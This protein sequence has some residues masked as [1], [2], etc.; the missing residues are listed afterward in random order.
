MAEQAYPGYLYHAFACDRNRMAEGMKSQQ[1]GKWGFY[2][3]CANFWA[4]GVCQKRENKLRREMGLKPLPNPCGGCIGQSFLPLS[5]EKLKRHLYTNDDLYLGVYPACPDGTVQLLT[6]QFEGQKLEELHLQRA[7]D[8][9][10]IVETLGFEYL[11]EVNHVLSSARIFLF[12]EEPVTMQAAREFGMRILARGSEFISQPDF[13]SYDVMIPSRDSYQPD[14]FQDV[15]PLPLEGKSSQAGQ[16]YLADRHGQPLEAPWQKI[17]S[18][19]RISPQ[20]MAGFMLDSAHALDFLSPDWPAS[21]LKKKKPAPVQNQNLFDLLDQA[22]QEE[23]EAEESQPASGAATG[24]AN[25][26]DEERKAAERKAA[27]RNAEPDRLFDPED[28]C[29]PLVLTRSSRISVPKEK[30]SPRMQ[31]RLRQMAAYA[32][33]E[34]K[35][36]ER[37]NYSN[38]QTRR[39]ISQS[40]ETEE[41]ILLPFGLEEQLRAHLQ[42]AGIPYEIIDETQHGAPLQLS[43][44]GELRPQQQKALADLE[45]YDTGIVESATGSG[46]TVMGAALIAQKQCSALVVV[47]SREILSGWLRDMKTFLDFS[48]DKIKGPGVLG[49]GR[50]TLNGRVDLAMVQSLQKRPDLEEILSAYG[51]II[52]DECHHSFAKTYQPLFAQSRARLRYGFSATPKRTDQQEPVIYM[53]LGPVRTRFTAKDQAASQNFGRLF[54]QVMTDAVLPLQARPPL[55]EAYQLLV[56]NEERNALIQRQAR[57]CLDAGRSV[58][59]LTKHREHA[60]ILYE[61]MKN[62]A[63]QTVL[64]VGGLPAREKK[65]MKEKLEHQDPDKSFLMIGTGAYIGEGFNLPRLDTLLLAAPVSA[66][67]LISQ[68]SGRLHREYP[69]KK[70]VM[71]YDFVDMNLPVFVRMAQKREAAYIKN[72]YRAF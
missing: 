25:G 59:V 23:K 18:L 15:V 9:A 61:R 1:T 47:P 8:L 22:A 16:A 5:P 64:L 37:L 19:K 27:Q 21:L 69:G 40:S 24:P 52:V 72:G 51:M 17:R 38:Y 31:N 29:G 71:I 55:A 41:A 54:H 26:A 3:S 30:L 32:N 53:E 35:E 67:M 57:E 2:I 65:E 63:Q 28:V 60:R 10:F 62:D 13:I 39:I 42:A 56:E 33:P 49:G 44:S 12:F 34:Y 46:K 50:N 43:F 58:L 36:N 6:W 14:A 11:F 48:Q 4:E 70:N 20:A 68:Y 66:D 7:K 45:P